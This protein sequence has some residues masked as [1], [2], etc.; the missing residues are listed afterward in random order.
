MNVAIA[1]IKREIEKMNERIKMET[2]IQAGKRP[3]IDSE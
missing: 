2:K 1:I 3:E